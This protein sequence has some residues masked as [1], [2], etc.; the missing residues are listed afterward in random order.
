M[1]DQL[2][3][4]PVAET[5]WQSVLEGKW[6]QWMAHQNRARTPGAWNASAIIRDNPGVSPDLVAALSMSGTRFDDPL[7]SEIIAKDAQQEGI[8]GRTLGVVTRPVTGIFWNLYDQGVSRPFRL[9]TQLMQGQ[10]PGDAYRASGQG[11][12]GNYIT[13]RRAGND[14]S[15]FGDS[16]LIAGRGT[17]D[18]LMYQGSSEPLLEYMEAG[19]TPEQAISYTRSYMADTQSRVAFD[20]SRRLAESTMLHK[21]KDG[22]TTSYHVTPARAMFQP[23]T[24]WIAP[25]TAPYVAITGSADLIMQVG[26]DPANPIIGRLNNIARAR[27]TAVASSRGLSPASAHD[28]VVAAMGGTKVDEAAYAYHGGPADIEGPITGGITG[29]TAEAVQYA[30][31]TGR[32]YVLDPEKLPENARQVISQYGAVEQTIDAQ[33]VRD[34][35]GR[36]PDEIIAAAR[37]YLSNDPDASANAVY[38]AMG[39]RT[40][41]GLLAD[42]IDEI[43]Q[44]ELRGET[45]GD[46]F[47]FASFDEARA[48]VDETF[49]NADEVLPL[50]DELHASRRMQYRDPIFSRGAELSDEQAELVDRMLRHSEADELI[51][52]NAEEVT[53]VGS[54]TKAELEEMERLGYMFPDGESLAAYKVYLDEVAEAG[55]VRSRGQWFV[56]PRTFDK[57]INERRGGRRFV[58]WVKGAK[59]HELKPRLPGMD[60]AD[61]LRLA[62]STDEVEI[63]AV[64]QDWYG[65]ARSQYK[66]PKAPSAFF[67][68]GALN[69]LRRGAPQRGARGAQSLIPRYG[70]RLSNYGRRLVAQMGN[71]SLDP[72]D[73]DTS[74]DTI[75]SWADLLGVNADE[76]EATVRIMAD[77]GD[78]LIDPATRMPAA[79]RHR[80]QL[81]QERMFGWLADDLIAKGHDPEYVE[82][83]LREWKESAVRL[84]QYN[85]NAVGTPMDLRPAR[86]RRVANDRGTLDIDGSD[87]L[88]DSQLGHRNLFM[89][90]TREV[91]RTTAAIRKY[92]EYYREVSGRS[93][94]G[95][96]TSGTQKVVD[97]LL[98]GWRNLA[99][100]RIGW[101]MRVLPD[102]MARM[103]AYGFSDLGSHPLS[104]IMMS[105]G[106]KGDTLPNGQSLRELTEMTG[107]GAD[108]GIFHGLDDLPYVETGQKGASWVPTRA[109]N[110]DGVTLTPKGAKGVGRRFLQLNQSRL[111][112]VVADH[113]TI[114]DAIEYLLTTDEGAEIL[115]YIGQRTAPDSTLGRVA[116]GGRDDIR[117]TLEAINAQRHQYTGG[118]WV[119]RNADGVWVHSDGSLVNMYDMNPMSGRPYT[120]E[121]LIAELEEMGYVGQRGGRPGS[122]LTLAELR[123]MRMSA[124]G[125]PGNLLSTNESY[126]IT[127]Q[128]NPEL[129]DLMRNGRTMAVPDVNV[130][131]GRAARRI[132]AESGLGDTRSDYL[133]V[134]AEDGVPQPNAYR[135]LDAAAASLREGQEIL[136]VDKELLPPSTFVGG[137]GAQTRIPLNGAEVSP[138]GTISFDAVKAR[139]DELLERGEDALIGDDMT[140]ADFDRLEGYL[141]NAYTPEHPPVQKVAVPDRPYVNATDEKKVI[142]TL[143]RWIGRNPSMFATRRPFVTLRTWELIAEHYVHA[144][145]AVRKQIMDAAMNAGVGD[146]FTGFVDASLKARGWTKPQPV[147]AALTLDE[148]TELSWSQ[149]V[150]DTKDLFYDLTKGGAWQDGTRLVFPFADAWW[151]VLTRWT[152]L[153]N[154]ARTGAQPLK[155]LRRGSQAFYGAESS[156][157]FDT[158]DQGERVFTFPGTGTLH[159]VLQGAG[160]PFRFDPQVSAE[161]LTFVDFG[162]PTL[163]MRPGFSPFVQLSAG[164]ARNT[165]FDRNILPD[166]MRHLYDRT[167]FGDF[168]PPASDDPFD[169]ASLFLPTWARRVISRIYEGEYD[170]RYGSTIGRVLN[171][172]AASSP[173]D[174]AVDQEAAQDMIKQAQDVGSW[175]A[176]VDIIS[177]FITPAQPRNVVELIRTN[178]NGAEVTKSIAALATDWYIIRDIYG[179][180]QAIEMFQAMYGVDPLKLAPATWASEKRPATSEAFRYLTEHPEL[181]TEMRYTLMGWLPEDDGEFDIDA[182]RRQKEQGT[183]ENLSPQDAVN[184]MGHAAG[185][186]RMG[187]LQEQRDALFA[188]AEQRWGGTDNDAY[189]FFRDEVVAPWYN[190]ARA[191]IY[192]QYWA[193]EPGE[194]PTGLTNRPSYE[195]VLKE[196]FRVG[197]PG[198]RANQLGRE[199]DPE[200]LGFYEFATAQWQQALAISIREGWGPQWWETSTSE[201]NG[202]VAIRSAVARNLNGYVQGMVGRSQEAAEW[203]VSTVF[204]PLLEG[205]DWQNPIII[206]PTSPSDELLGYADQLNER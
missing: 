105:L 113:A 200:L 188:Q 118:D 18:P 27:R 124:D 195:K 45:L 127:R 193:Y 55:A 89:P 167:F 204:Q 121:E 90:S 198:S 32:V 203:V 51:F 140:K 158:N 98:A 145:P 10:S 117:R 196:V 187:A 38:D 75:M 76:L 30:G 108:N 120:R 112:A 86:G 31:D 123:E 133:W 72:Y 191:D 183:R 15:M 17:D 139:A 184:W 100:L 62:D 88:L 177:S 44:A 162:D 50:I 59:F 68:D 54:F 29:S 135:D 144:A 53:P 58:E 77:E 122:S 119:G 73:F 12:V 142:D 155:L 33:R 153:M 57:W 138:S 83:I 16:G 61:I 161:Q 165:L 49:D 175:I 148:I 206:S 157:F 47:S 14:V 114:D 6:G 64:L 39:G 11:I 137:K 43:I 111:A 171:A 199:L 66:V 79:P 52:T 109:T 173:R 134:V 169:T 97:G 80:A 103:Y 189:R 46:E 101:I 4:D 174:V 106:A 93:V 180:D 104:S 186:H 19:A 9:A 20:E 136:A 128:G 201:T 130:A 13:N 116:A 151:E 99:L 81:V 7:L 35:F 147:Q 48:F 192:L 63:A 92:T 197:T 71:N 178:E 110:P 2:L 126:I 24:E 28:E 56:H 149:A 25:E 96:G 1:A 91:R 60:N 152:G 65:S 82:K 190:Q 74:F 172:Y 42:E 125:M 160:M 150:E 85:E 132:F 87:P 181:E 40:G 156:G 168:A 78:G 102:E 41:Q 8:L 164:A 194:G 179:Q 37:Q 170:D 185:S 143:F 176:T 115:R 22:R 94:A 36:E 5:S 23:F 21:T 205:Y 67:G 131:R 26:V 129:L 34:V 3:A 95:I 84:Q 202:A 70:Q 69:A 154:P 166:S 182:Y 159:N 146:R 141:Q 107:L 163:A